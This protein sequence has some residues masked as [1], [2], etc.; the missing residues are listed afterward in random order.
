MRM[1]V[2]YSAADWRERKEGGGDDPAAEPISRRL[3]Q[4]CIVGE[5]R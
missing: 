4:R 2:C 3:A 1:C 5:W